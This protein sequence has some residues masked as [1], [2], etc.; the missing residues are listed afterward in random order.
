MSIGSVLQGRQYSAI[1]VNRPLV[2]ML[3][4]GCWRGLLEGHSIGVGTTP[5]GRCERVRRGRPSFSIRRHWGGQWIIKVVRAATPWFRT[6]ILNARISVFVVSLPSN[7]LTV[8]T[9]FFVDGAVIF[10]HAE[11]I[12]LLPILNVRGGIQD[13]TRCCQ[14]SVSLKHGQNSLRQEIKGR[15]LISKKERSP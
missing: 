6:R 10:W 1:A 13:N 12:F 11:S 5:C 2:H 14:K 15:C 7:T 3:V 8:E 4:Q 9:E